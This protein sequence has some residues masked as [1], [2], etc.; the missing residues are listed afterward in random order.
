MYRLSIWDNPVN[1]LRRG[2]DYVPH[3]ERS[4]SDV[5]VPLL[6]T[7]IDSDIIIGFLDCCYPYAVGGRADYRRTCGGT[8]QAACRLERS[9]KA[10]AV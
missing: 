1:D 7:Q 2:T 9:R 5:R 3:T 6:C 10:G 4:M 8:I